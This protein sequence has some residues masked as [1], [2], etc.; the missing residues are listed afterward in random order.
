M[1][2]IRPFE[3]N[4]YYVDDT[5]EPCDIARLLNYGVQQ[6]GIGILFLDENRKCV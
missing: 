3:E 5:A 2:A 6:M 1:D 4:A